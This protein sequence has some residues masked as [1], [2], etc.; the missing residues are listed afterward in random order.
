[1]LVILP[2]SLLG[3]QQTNRPA[4][5]DIDNDGDLD[6]FIGMYLGYPINYGRLYFY[7][8]I[9]NNT[10]YQFVLEEESLC[11]IGKL[12]KYRSID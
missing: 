3:S 2:D 11:V 7:R 5:C 1:M 6:L 9:G 10:N 12:D 4:L 8:N